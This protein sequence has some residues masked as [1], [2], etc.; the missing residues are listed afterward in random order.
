MTLVNVVHP[1]VLSKSEFKHRGERNTVATCNNF[2][3]WQ[4]NSRKRIGIQSVQN[5]PK[6]KVWLIGSM[7]DLNYPVVIAKIDLKIAVNQIPTSFGAFRY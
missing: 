4:N 2:V 5:A 1:V 3:M 6:W 7:L